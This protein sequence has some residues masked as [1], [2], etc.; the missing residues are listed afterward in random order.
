MGHIRSGRRVG[1]LGAGAVGSRA[2]QVQVQVGRREPGAP[3]PPSAS[4][5]N[6]AHV[7][8][9]WRPLPS[10]T[11]GQTPIF[12]LSFSQENVSLAPSFTRSMSERCG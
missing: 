10:N 8:T 3:V 6:G 9:C 12:L 1:C 11:R 4:S 2:V 7:P 5:P